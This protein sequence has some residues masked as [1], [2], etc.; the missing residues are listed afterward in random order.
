LSATGKAPSPLRSAGARQNGSVL[1]IVLWI[2]L[3]LVAIALYFA[4]SMT[5][6]LRASDN[7][8]SMLAADQAIEGAARYVSNVLTN[9]ATN[10]IV[11]F[12]Y[13]Y[14]SEAVAVGNATD[15]RANAHFW[16]IGRSDNQSSLVAQDQMA[17]GLVDEASK[18]NLNTASREVLAAVVPGLDAGSAERIVQQVQR[19]YFKS[20]NDARAY[21]PGDT[22][23]DP[24]R[25]G[26]SSN[27]FEVTGRLRLEGRALEETQL[28]VRRNRDVVPLS[29]T[30]QVLRP[31]AS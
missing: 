4:N 28:V 9:Q 23:L 31:S 25:L 18:L 20:L 8:V 10:G 19:Q 13:D 27:Y 16:L 5:F 29:R 1:I 17:F 3:G 30:R 12:P 22:A 14:A 15:D 24:K 26:V 2:T 11:P 7:R 21:I 6:E